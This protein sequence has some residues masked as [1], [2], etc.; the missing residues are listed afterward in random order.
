MGKRPGLRSLAGAVTIVATAAAATV[1][2]VAGAGAVVAG[3]GFTTTNA[4]YN[5]PGTC[6][7]GPGVVNCNIYAGKDDVWINGGPTNGTNPLSDGTYFFVVGVPGGE[8]SS[9][10]DESPY[11]DG[12]A[13]ASNLSDDYDQ[14]TN[15]TFTVA[16]HHI[17]GTSGT[18]VLDDGKLQLFPYSDTTNPGG[19]YFVAICRI[20]TPGSPGYPVDPLQ[21]KYDNFKVHQQIC[22]GDECT[23]T[24]FGTLSGAK[25][26]DAN[27][28]G[29]RD[30]GEVGIANWAIDF[31]D[32]TANTLLTDTNGE[33]SVNLSPDHY[34]FAEEQA[35]NTTGPFN[36]PEWVQTGNTVDQSVDT[37]G[38]ETSALNADKSY[39]VTVADGGSTSGLLFGNVC[40][41]PGGGLTLGFWSNKNGQALESSADLAFLSGLNLIQ[42]KA[43]SPYWQPFDP[44]TAK[45]LSSW[46]LSANATN[47]AY[48]LSAQL[49]AM[50]LN[51]RHGFVRGGG[52]VY[53]GGSINALVSVS[54]LMAAANAKLGTA[55]YTVAASSDRTLEETYKSALDAANNNVNF[56]QST[57]TRCPAPRF[58]GQ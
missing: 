23:P 22:I 38:G 26:Y 33:F 46:L 7:N 5:G 28:N 9:L 4:N 14:Y 13:T 1:L 15:R 45:Q 36:L 11:V 8:N 53:V 25:Y 18:H 3:A 48:M 58:P 57:P 52:M 39:S 21:C 19:E 12:A 6:F 29:Q 27:A 34:T 30:P 31:S 47:M 10:N 42:P 17:T 54:D 41:G 20:D 35:T 43:S 50:E 40:L 51:V 24:P 16:D 32:G 44:T 2:F 37:G 55:P 49:A 56:V